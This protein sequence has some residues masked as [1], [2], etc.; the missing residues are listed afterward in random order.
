VLKAVPA[1]ATGRS[2]ATFL[3]VARVLLGLGLSP[4]EHGLP[5]PSPFPYVA[6]AREGT[7][8]AAVLA[9]AVALGYDVAPASGALGDGP[10]LLAHAEGAA[11]TAPIPLFQLVRGRGRRPG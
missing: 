5:P 3:V 6:A 1:P 8:R 2:G 11:A 10:E 7:K 4:R 9:A